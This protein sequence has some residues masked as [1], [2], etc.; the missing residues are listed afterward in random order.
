MNANDWEA[1]NSSSV[2]DAE[3]NENNPGRY[4]AVN[5]YGDENLSPIYNQMIYG[6]DGKVDTASILQYPG[7]KRWHRK[8]YN[9]KDLVDYDTENLK[10]SFDTLVLENKLLL[11]EFTKLLPNENE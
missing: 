4:D 6:L 3:T 7:L 9:E 8:G 11:K 5:R 10:T 2:A 1:T